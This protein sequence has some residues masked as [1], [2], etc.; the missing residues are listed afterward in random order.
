MDPKD[1]EAPGD[2]LVDIW[3]QCTALAYL[4]GGWEGQS[5]SGQLPAPSPEGHASF[6]WT[7]LTGD[8][9]M[10]VWRALKENLHSPLWAGEVGGRETSHP[11]NSL[12]YGQ[13]LN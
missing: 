1:V 12:L 10:L 5:G 2:P 4:P 11:N 6:S 9:H 13:L 8:K 7:Y 3:A